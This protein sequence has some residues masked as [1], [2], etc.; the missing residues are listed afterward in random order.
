MKKMSKIVTF[1]LMF[2]FVLVIGVPVIAKADITVNVAKPLDWQGINVHAWTKSK[3]DI[4]T[5]PGIP[6]SQ[7]GDKFSVTIEAN[8]S[9]KISLI[10]NDGGNKYQTVN[11]DGLT[12]SD[13]KG[14]GLDSGSYDVTIISEKDSNG[15]LKWTMVRTGES[16]AVTPKVNENPQIA[17]AE[18]TVKPIE[19]NIVPAVSSPK[20]ADSST[21]LIICI[22][23]TAILSGIVGYFARKK[24]MA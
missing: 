14:S 15:K 11:I 19:D 6:L 2:S 18:P 9:E 23:L 3:G 12:C 5:W 16:S 10:L 13:G 24:I 8:R 17:T 22:A 7:N 1:I 21:V 4:T 20:T